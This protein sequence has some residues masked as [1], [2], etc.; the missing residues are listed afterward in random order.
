[1]YVFSSNENLTTGTD[2]HPQGWLSVQI[3]I[4]EPASKT[5]I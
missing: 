5:E 4:D 2:A 3:S 1:M